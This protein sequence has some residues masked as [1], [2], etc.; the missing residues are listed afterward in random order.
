M[1]DV[2]TQDVLPRI[3]LLPRLLRVRDSCWELP[4]SGAMFEHQVRFREPLQAVCLDQID[5]NMRAGNRY[6]TSRAGAVLPIRRLIRGSHGHSAPRIRFGMQGVFLNEAVGWGGQQSLDRRC[7]TSAQGI[8][9]R[10]FSK[11]DT[12][13]LAHEV[14]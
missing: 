5:A 13:E 11:P 14:R 8:E 9:P 4:P 1:S 3:D 2:A 7:L 10:E 12:S 6:Q